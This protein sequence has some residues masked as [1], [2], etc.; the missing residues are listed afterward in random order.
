MIT[1]LKGMKMVQEVVMDV[2]IGLE[3]DMLFQEEATFLLKERILI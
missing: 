1:V 2:S 3:L